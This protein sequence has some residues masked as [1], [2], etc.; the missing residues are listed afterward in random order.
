[1]TRIRKFVRWSARSG[2]VLALSAGLLPTAISVAAEKRPI[3]VLDIKGAIGPATADYV[4]RGFA[5]AQ[6][7]GA[8]VIVL[9][10]DT[11]GGLVD[12]MRTIIQQ[13]LASPIPV[14]GFVA[15][16]GA[17]A[18]SAGTYIL[19]ACHLSGLRPRS[20]PVAAFPVSRSRARP[21]PRT[22]VRGRSRRPGWRTRS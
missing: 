1:M 16:S 18:A 11:P 12:S 19:Y 9:R 10:M 22:V 2:L 15:P 4:E 14:V 3:A 6:N 8:E 20:R 17:H 13:I 21:N 7:Q 5:K